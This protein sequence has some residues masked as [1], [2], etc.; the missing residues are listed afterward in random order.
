MSIVD[1]TSETVASI[2]NVMAKIEPYFPIT[3]SVMISCRAGPIALLGKVAPGNY[4][5]RKVAL[6][7]LMTIVSLIAIVAMMAF[8]RAK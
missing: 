1:N 6:I 3:T 5:A 8:G 7:V 2:S 4:K